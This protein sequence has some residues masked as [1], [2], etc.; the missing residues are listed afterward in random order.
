[1]TPVTKSDGALPKAAPFGLVRMGGGVPKDKECGNAFP[2]DTG[3]NFDTPAI[4]R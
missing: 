4:G 3:I 2:F 1:M